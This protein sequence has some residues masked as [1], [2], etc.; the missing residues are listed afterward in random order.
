MDMREWLIMQL[1]ITNF[2]NNRRVMKLAFSHQIQCK[3]YRLW[4]FEPWCFNMLSLWRSSVCW[5]ILF[6]WLPSTNVISI[7][8][9]DSLLRELFLRVLWIIFFVL[10]VLIYLQLR[11]ETVWDGSYRRMGILI[12]A[13]FIINYEVSCLLSFLG[14]VFGRLRLLSVFLSL[15]GPPYGTRF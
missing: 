2:E 13:H 9:C 15:F 5:V 7:I 1:N 3:V 12:S 10:W 4:Y 11:M 14:K 8:F 6:C